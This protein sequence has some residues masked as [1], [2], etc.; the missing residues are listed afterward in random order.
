MPNY[1]KSPDWPLIQNWSLEK[2]FE[3]TGRIL[4]KLKMGANTST[5]L[6]INL[7]TY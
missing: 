3:I 6:L 1:N 7:P 5:Y 4:H 2:L